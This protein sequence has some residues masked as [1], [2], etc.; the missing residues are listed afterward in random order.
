MAFAWHGDF[1]FVTRGALKGVG[2]QFC[3][4]SERLVYTT[5]PYCYGCKLPVEKP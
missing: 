4:E 5:L 1:R 3:F 2:Q